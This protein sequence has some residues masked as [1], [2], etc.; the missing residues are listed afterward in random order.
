MKSV[1]VAEHCLAWRRSRPHA[2][3]FSQ[4]CNYSPF[5]DV[6]PA[7][8]PMCPQYHREHTHAWCL[9]PLTP[10]RM[11]ASHRR[12]RSLTALSVA[13]PLWR[14]GSLRARLEGVWAGAGGALFTNQRPRATGRPSTAVSAVSAC[15]ARARDAR[16]APHWRSWPSMDACQARSPLRP[17]CGL[18]RVAG[19]ALWLRVGASRTVAEASQ[20]RGAQEP[21]DWRR[22][23]R[24]ESWGAN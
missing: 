19:Q 5:S 16:A 10:C 1:T 7:Y 6:C 23:R 21:C 12:L 14:G 22:T 9:A 20:R 11:I 2:A 15:T 24:S 3:V 4:R 18:R 13:S 8:S 17:A